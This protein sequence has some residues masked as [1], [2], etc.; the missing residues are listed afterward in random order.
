MA[1][2]IESF[3]AKLQEEGVEAGKKEAQRLRDEAQKDAERIVAEAEKQA[4]GIRADAKAEA[5]ET[6][7][8]ARTELRLAARDAIL[9]L[10]EAVTRAVRVI[11]L[12]KAGEHLEDSEF[13]GK[14][15]HEIVVNYTDSD[16]HCKESLEINV[17][18]EMRDKL[19]SW[20]LEE[21]ADEASKDTHPS[22]D[23]KGTLTDAGFEYT[24]AGSTVEVTRDSVVE[25][26]MD[27]VGPEVRKVV[28]EAAETDQRDDR[29][30]QADRSDNQ[31]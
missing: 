23:L 19:V 5:D 6:L 4:E 12:R 7:S 30:D 27:L 1:E 9:R 8:R 15:L 25:T 26:L 13:L 22:I 31:E 24:A 28:R 2:T 21:I 3:V 17:R 20:A 18:P 16:L 10:Q 29:S 14:L 11:V